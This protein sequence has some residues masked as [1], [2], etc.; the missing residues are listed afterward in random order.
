MVPKFI[1]V[2]VLII[3]AFSLLSFIVPKGWQI[4]GS[5]DEKYDIGLWKIGGHDSS[6][7][8]GVIR[9]NKTDYFESDYGSLIQKISSQKYLGKR[10]RMT[11]FMKSRSVKAWAGFY[12]RADKEDV[13][14]PLAF[15]TMQDTPVK[16]TTDWA[17][18]K[19]EIDV[20]LNASKIVFGAV[21]HGQ[22]QVWFDDLNFEVVGN[23]A[24]KADY[25]LC[26]TSLSREPLNLDFEK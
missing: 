14:E 26:D 4:S 15:A 6:K 13:K 1:R 2:S 16:G 24:I 21:L 23:S 18:Y 19:L 3:L 7:N 8:C 17:P 11:G 10:I 22:G 20:P 9:S 12:L 5:A 25:V